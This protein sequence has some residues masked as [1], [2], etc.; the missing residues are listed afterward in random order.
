MICVS[1]G[2]SRHRHMKAEHKHLAE[3]GIRLVELRLDYVRSSINIPRLINDRPSPAVVTIRRERDGGRFAGS[4]E[5]R[6]LLLRTAIAEGV[7][8][9]DLEEDVAAGIPRFGNTKRVISYHNFRKTPEDLDVIHSRMRGL[10]PDVIKI[11]TMANH[12]HDNVRMLSMVWRN[13]DIPTVGLC[14]GDIGLPSRIL[15][16]RYGSPFTY[17]TFHHERALAP[18][19][20]SFDQLRDIYRYDEI[21]SA[22]EIYGVI[23]DPIGHSLS[24]LIHNAAFANLGMNRLYL[25][26]RVPR[27]D[28]GSF[29]EDAEEFGL[30]GLSVTIPH[31]E[32]IRDYLTRADAAVEGIGA[33]NTV[34]FEGKERIGYNTDSLAAMGALEEAAGV[35]DVPVRDRFKGKVA[36]V[37]GAGG[38]GKAIAYGLRERNAAVVLTDVDASAAEELAERLDCRAAEW[39]SRHKISCDVLVNCTPVGMHPNVDETPFDKSRFKASMLVF[40]V[41][42]NPER[43]LFLK[44]A[45]EKHCRT[46]S[47]MDMFVRQAAL[48][49]KLFTGQE[50]PAELMRERIRRQIAA[51]RV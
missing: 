23:A 49:F 28:L 11:C 38:A 45:A 46:V 50:G 9:V 41:V 10:D 13:R 37:L 29:L 20:I 43:T 8:Y 15:C 42:Y 7:D 47:G 19:Q 36:M 26:F 4:E 30:K 32:R 21:D 39:E 16:G 51:V 6:L 2:R 24:P 1:I 22:T 27:E 12:P 35:A 5:Q 17:A 14:M 25:P 44:E 34:V 33:C 31:K 48:Q 3:Q 18:G 40:D